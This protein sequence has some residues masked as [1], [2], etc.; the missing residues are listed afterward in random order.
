MLVAAIGSL[1]FLPIGTVCSVIQII[2]LL[3]LRER[4]K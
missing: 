4:L 3:A 1:W 2:L